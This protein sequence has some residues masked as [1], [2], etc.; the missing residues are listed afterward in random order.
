MLDLVKYACNP[1][2]TR[3]RIFHEEEDQYCDCYQRDR[4]RIIY[5]GA[6]RK[7]QYKTQV[8][9]NYEND[10]YRTRLTHSLEVAQIARSLSRKLRFNE[11]LTEAI[12]LAHDLGHP[13][14]GHAGEDALNEMTMHHLGF[15]HNIQALR[16]L[17]FLE[18]RYIK[19][20]GMNLTWETLEGVAKHNGPITG[21]NRINSNK[22]IHKFMLDYDSYYKL[23]LDNFSS[24]EAQI[25]SISDDIAYNM[26]DIDDG[27]RAKILVIE[28]LLELPL[29]GDILKKVIDDN[30]G[31]SVSDNRIVH[32]FLRRTVDIMLMDIISQVTNNIKEYDIRS[33]D[34][35]RK[36]G[37]VFVHFSEEMN[38]Y[39]IGLQ[40]FLRTKLYNYYKVKRV[41]N[42]VKRIIKELFQVFYDDPQILPSDW[43]VKAMDAN[44]IDRSIVICDFISGMTD[45]FAI[46]EHRKIFDTT[47]EMLVF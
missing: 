44:L 34:D 46:Q 25:A 8:F 21:E 17:T 4:D 33:H 3:G 40:N 11:D 26:H 32:E 30:S 9:I 45:R 18:K 28:E 19:F 37:K 2:E 7:L 15:D 12:S 10:Y 14:F 24:A 47:Y 31:L 38:Q 20:D 13:P 27:I 29:I 1:T 16:I 35:I 22:K 36:L 6:F 23:D 43:G 5:S 41:K 42:K 39:K